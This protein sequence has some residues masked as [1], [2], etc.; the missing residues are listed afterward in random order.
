MKIAIIGATGHA[1][2][3]I[4]KEALARHLDVTAI[5]RNAKKLTV[6]VPFIEKDL[7]DLTTEDLASFDVVID[8]FNAPAGKEEMHQTSLAHLAK[9]LANTSTRLLVVGGASSL[10]ID[11]E[12]TTRMIDQVP[13]DAPFYPTAFHMS[14]ALVHLKDTNGLRWTY[15]SPAA[16]FNPTG[17]RTG[18]Y[19][20][21]DD[22]LHK[23][24]QGESVISMAD[25]A[26]ALIDE[27]LADEHENEHISVVSQ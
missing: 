9:I 26:I 11:P 10:F 6:A 23:N 5:V 17:E 21:N 19:Q 14:Q 15:I 8:A 27:V 13:E 24:A 16:F 3:L 22:F 20:L 7:Y 4:L 1:G 18:N 25:Y 2:S 12:K